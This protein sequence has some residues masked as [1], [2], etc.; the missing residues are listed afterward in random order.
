[1]GARDLEKV[2]A[3]AGRAP[4]L[5]ALVDARPLRT[6]GCRKKCPADGLLRPWC[7]IKTGYPMTVGCLMTTGK[8]AR[9]DRGGDAWVEVTQGV[10]FPADRGVERASS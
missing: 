10:A 2:L 3:L 4:M 6:A 8:P 9:M 5:R 1:M 7:H